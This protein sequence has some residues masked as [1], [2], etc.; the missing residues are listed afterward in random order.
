MARMDFYLPDIFCIIYRADTGV[1]GSILLFSLV[2]RAVLLMYYLSA[3]YMATVT[4][5]V[6]VYTVVRYIKKVMYVTT[7]NNLATNKLKYMI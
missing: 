2:M 1:R 6:R 3:L 5:D 4:A 7:S